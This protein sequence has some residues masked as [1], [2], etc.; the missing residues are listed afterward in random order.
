RRA[1]ALIEISPSSVPANGP[2]ILKQE[3]IG[4]DNFKSAA[5]RAGAFDRLDGRSTTRW[6]RLEQPS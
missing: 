2:A 6:T 1:S 4:A 5:E 3:T